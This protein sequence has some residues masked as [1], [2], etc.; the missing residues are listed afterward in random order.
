MDTDVGLGDS[1]T[2]SVRHEQSPIWDLNHEGDTL[3]SASGAFINLLFIVLHLYYLRDYFW[4][5]VEGRLDTEEDEDGC[6]AANRVAAT[7]R[8]FLDSIAGMFIDFVFYAI[9]P[10]YQEYPL[11]FFL[12]VWLSQIVYVLIYCSYMRRFANGL[13]REKQIRSVPK[14]A[15]QTADG[16]VLHMETNK[17]RAL[18]T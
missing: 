3:T 6:G 1:N 4:D 14:I 10:L 9:R 11:T 16:S 2:G 13:H 5:L 17:W 18:A 15:L 7:L 8:V 12:I